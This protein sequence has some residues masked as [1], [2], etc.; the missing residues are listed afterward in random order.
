MGAHFTIK[1]SR[2]IREEFP[3]YEKLVEGFRQHI[4]GQ[5]PAFLGRDVAYDHPNTPPTV[6]Q[7]LRHIH[8][9]VPLDDHPPWWET[10]T[11]VFRRT[12]LMNSPEKD[13]ALIYCYDDLQDVY[14]LLTIIGPDAHDNKWMSYLKDIAIK[15]EQ[16]ITRS[17]VSHQ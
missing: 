4:R 16:L 5:T 14:Y 7:F 2:E 6:K 9:C 17:S 1:A 13:Y 10:V 3:E 12:N 15:T 8:I 11:E